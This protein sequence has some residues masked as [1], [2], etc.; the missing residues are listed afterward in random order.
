MIYYYIIYYNII[1]Q[2]CST[3]IMAPCCIMEFKGHGT[4]TCAM[5]KYI[6]VEGSWHHTLH[7]V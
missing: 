1:V 2:L 3:R 5:Q 6:I 4:M 7:I